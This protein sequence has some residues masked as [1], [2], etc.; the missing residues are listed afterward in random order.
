V[1]IEILDGKGGAV[2]SFTGRPGEEAP[3]G[4]PFGGGGGGGGFGQFAQARVSAR[5]GLNRF[6][7]NMRY[8]SLFEIPRGAVLWAAGGN[9]GPKVVLGT[10]QVK[11]TAG[12]WTQTQSFE[13]KPDPRIKTTPAEYEEQLKLARE[14]GAQVKELY[15]NLAKLRDIKQQATELG[16]R[17]QKAGKGDDIAKAARALNDKLTTVEGGLTQIQGEGGQDALNFPGQ[18]D[19]QYLVLYGAVSGPDSKPGPHHYQRFEELKP[20]LTKLLGQLKQ[21][22][23]ADLAKFNDLVRGKGVAPVILGS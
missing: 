16:E 18:L 20:G 19:N 1:Q 14:V 4:P 12:S 8:D 13:V 17:I 22:L 21:I 6:T 7:W 11:I 10:Y 3:A 2:A 5:G 23:D 9:A 15:A